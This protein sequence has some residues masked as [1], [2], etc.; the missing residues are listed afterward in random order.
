MLLNFHLYFSKYFMGFPGDPVVKDPPA[1]AG[2]MGWSLVQED[3][4][5][6][7]TATRSSIFPQENPMDRLWKSQTWL[8][9]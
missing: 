4:L 2:G 1:N 8:S 7:E 5:E 3:L 9:S 6:K